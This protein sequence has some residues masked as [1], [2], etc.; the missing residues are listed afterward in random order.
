MIATSTPT[1]SKP[2]SDAAFLEMLPGIEKYAR[3]A[4]RGLLAEAREEAVQNV[5]ANA[6]VA[7]RRLV[8]LDKAALAYPTVLARYGVAHVRSGRRVGARLNAHKPLSQVFL[9]AT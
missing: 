6:L 7:Y 8:E 4:F 9:S 3:S 2:R 5:I 1:C